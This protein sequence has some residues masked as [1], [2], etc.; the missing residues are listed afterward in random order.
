MTASAFIRVAS[1]VLTVALTTRGFCAGMTM[2]TEY[3][4]SST[5]P[6]VL[7]EW[8]RNLTQGLALADSKRIPIK[9]GQYNG[10]VM[11]PQKCPDLVHGNG[12]RLRLRIPVST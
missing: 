10:H 7:G 11:V 5:G 8:N 9:N 4:E 1:V 2:T 6:I 3:I 12:K